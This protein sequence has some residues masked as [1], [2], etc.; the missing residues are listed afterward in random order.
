MKHQFRH[1][2]KYLISQQEYICLRARLKPVLE[3]DENSSSPEGY[4]VRSL[5]FD[6]MYN[7]A[8]RDKEEGIQNRE[9]YRIRIYDHSSQ[10]IRFERKVKHNQLVRKE[11]Q[12]LSQSDVRQLCEGQ[13]EFLLSTGVPLLQRFYGHCRARLMRPVVIVD[14]LREA[15]RMDSGNV[16]IT[17][18]KQLSAGPPDRDFFTVSGYQ[19][20]VFDRPVM[21][22]EIKYD[23]YLPSLARDLVQ[24]HSHNLMAVS[25]YM[26]CR[27]R[28]HTY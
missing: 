13:Q 12:L 26:L 27:K 18:D 1:E 19:R 5:Y 10:I 8:L 14:Y 11:S 3:M 4:W 21:I 15:Y 7:S 9:K 6:D 23:D 20:S 17:F 24:A 16:R 25:K 2:L 28:L 22:M